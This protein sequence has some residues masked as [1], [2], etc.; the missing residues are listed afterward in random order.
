MTKED[1]K[2][3]MLQIIPHLQYAMEMAKKEG[4]PGL[5]ITLTKPDNSG[6]IV[7][8]FRAEEFL[9]DLMTLVDAPPLSDE[10]RR[11]AQAKELVDAIHNGVLP[12]HLEE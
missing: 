3:K 6:R 4:T 2:A 12:W 8:Q 1:I 11:D 9:S 7:C 10:H 5:A